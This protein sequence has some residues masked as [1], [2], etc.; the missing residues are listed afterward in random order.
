MQAGGTASCR[1]SHAAGCRIS[2]SNLERHGARIRVESEP[3]QGTT[4][5]VAFG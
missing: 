3:N 2:Y 4:V 5:T 1:A